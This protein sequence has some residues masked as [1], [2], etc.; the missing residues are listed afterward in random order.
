MDLITNYI[1]LLATVY[2]TIVQATV[3]QSQQRTGNHASSKYFIS[4][5]ITCFSTCN[6]SATFIN[7]MLLLFRLLDIKI[8]HKQPILSLKKVELLMVNSLDRVDQIM[9]YRI[10]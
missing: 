10:I 2:L 1:I 3:Y 5:F 7:N 6:I 4:S 8:I 9:D